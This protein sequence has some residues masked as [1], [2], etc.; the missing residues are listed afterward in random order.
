MT[1]PL[2]KSKTAERIRN[3]KASHQAQSPLEQP[4]P[5]A[6]QMPLPS[7][8]DQSQD[9]PSLSDLGDRP[10]EYK[11]KPLE[12]KYNEFFT[13]QFGP[14]LVLIL[15]WST[16]D[17]DKAAFYAPNPEECAGIAPHAARIVD[18]FS[19]WAHIPSEIHDIIT[20]SDDSLALAYV[21]TGYLH[22]IGVLEQL[23]PTFFGMF[24][25]GAAI[26]KPDKQVTGDNGKI[27]TP[28]F[29]QRTD[30]VSSVSTNGAIPVTSIPGLGAQWQS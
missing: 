11:P 22:R 18:R 2:P 24:N 20:T 8:L 28:I 7:S 13:Y 15:W 25:R 12:K 3:R 26:A 14:I 19:K 5:Q 29:S 10:Q 4:L 21:V 17:L 9:R 1:T 16:Q 30:P 27:P 23:G 6:Q